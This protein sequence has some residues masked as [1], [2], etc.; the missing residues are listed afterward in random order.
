MN[1]LC[2]NKTCFIL[3]NTSHGNTKK[4]I[5]RSLQITVGSSSFT[6]QPLFLEFVGLLPQCPCTNKTQLISQAKNQVK[7][8]VE[9]R[10]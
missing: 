7:S 4:V 9:S 8:N 5:K 1:R 10:V 6:T 3:A 2:R